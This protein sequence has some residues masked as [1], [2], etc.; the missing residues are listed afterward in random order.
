MN[1]E[2]CNTKIYKNLI[3]LGNQPIPDNLSSSLKLSIKKENLKPKLF[4]A[5]NV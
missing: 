5:T 2:I 1:C 3:N 4:I